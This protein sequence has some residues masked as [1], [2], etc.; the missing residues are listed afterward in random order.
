MA[1]PRRVDI[2]GVGRFQACGAFAVN[3]KPQ[4]LPIEPYN[5]ELPNLY[6]ALVLI[7]SVFLYYRL[8][9]LHGS[10]K[11]CSAIRAFLHDL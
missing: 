4:I 6:L 2:E 3:L 7:V 9:S 1:W 10:S 5:P 8:T 11:K